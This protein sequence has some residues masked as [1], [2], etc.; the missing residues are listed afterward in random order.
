MGKNANLG[1]LPT[2][3]GSG[4]AATVAYDRGMPGPERIGR[5]EDHPQFAG[6]WLRP[7][8]SRR[9]RA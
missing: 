3:A 9:R 6:V 8:A 5:V 2:V 4:A 1:E 7:G